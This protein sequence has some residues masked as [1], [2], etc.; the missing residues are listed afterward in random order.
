MMVQHYSSSG[1]APDERDFL[2]LS[3]D[4]LY[5]SLNDFKSFLE[6]IARESGSDHSDDVMKWLRDHGFR[7]IEESF[8]NGAEYALVA[9][10]GLK[11][12]AALLREEYSDPN[13]KERLLDWVLDAPYML[14]SRITA[15]LLRQ[16]TVQ[17][18]NEVDYEESLRDEH[19]DSLY[20]SEGLVIGSV[21]A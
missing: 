2:S 13:E 10:E 20:L 4:D 14:K 19:I 9:A 1:K 21:A 18:A 12:L 3:K 11:K 17:W 8:E 7:L 6:I 5:A 15:Q 16:Q